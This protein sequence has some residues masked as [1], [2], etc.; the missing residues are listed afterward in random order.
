MSCYFRHLKDILAEAGVE[1]TTANKK[2]VDQ[3]LHEIVGVAHKDCPTAWKNLKRQMANEAG[4]AVVVNKLR[5][6]L[7][8]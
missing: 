1:V 4:R 3:A 2:E 8:K 7:A 5:K 6:A